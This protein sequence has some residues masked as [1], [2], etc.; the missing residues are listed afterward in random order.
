MS[1]QASTAALRRSGQ[2]IIPQQHCAAGRPAS[3]S[4]CLTITNADESSDQR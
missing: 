2:E 3:G 4:F 1:I